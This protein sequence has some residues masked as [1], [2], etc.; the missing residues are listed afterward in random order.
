MSRRMIY[1]MLLLALFQQSASAQ[2]KSAIELSF[3]GR[4]D[5]HANDVSNFANRAYNDTMKLYG[6]SFGAEMAYRYKITKTFSLYLGAGYYRL[7][8]DK[9][10]ATMPFNA[11]GTRTARSIDYDDGTTNLAYSTSEYFYNNIAATLGAS[12]TFNAG[13]GYLLDFAL[14]A[15][16]YYSISQRYELM[17]GNKSYRTTNRKPVE[18]GINMTAGILKEFNHFYIRPGLIVPLY[19]N[20]KGDKV[21]FEDRKMNISKWFHG[22][23][24]ELRVGRYL[25]YANR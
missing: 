7:G 25:Q 8:I 16:W 3:L 5:R 4:Y 17:T 24:I 22:A 19:Q 2:H 9:I 6:K 13:K 20:L 23:G 14:E 18:A 11:P 10:R 1:L 15:K 21:F 12:K